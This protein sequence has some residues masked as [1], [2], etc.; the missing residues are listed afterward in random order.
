MNKLHALESPPSSEMFVE[1]DHIEV[2]FGQE[3]PGF[4]PFMTHFVPKT[5]TTVWVILVREL[6]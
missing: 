5:D 3:I 1:K 6:F 2:H 4:V